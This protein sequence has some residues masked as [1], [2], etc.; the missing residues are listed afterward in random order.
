MQKRQINQILFN[1]NSTPNIDQRHRNRQQ[2]HTHTHT[3]THTHIHT[4]THTLSLSHSLIAH[5]H[6]L[7][8]NRHMAAVVNQ[9]VA[10][11]IERITRG[12]TIH[13]I[14]LVGT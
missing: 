10:D 13:K 3:Y 1:H 12:D 7:A 5:S 9:Y 4:Y 2:T 14:T 6:T 11:Y 8:H